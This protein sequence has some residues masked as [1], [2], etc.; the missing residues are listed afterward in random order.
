M[1]RKTRLAQTQKR[2][3][4]GEVQ[5]FHSLDYHAALAPIYLESWGEEL[6]PVALTLHNVSVAPRE[7]PDSLTAHPLGLARLDA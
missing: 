2:S 5:L 4:L 6:M 3:Q 7:A 1:R